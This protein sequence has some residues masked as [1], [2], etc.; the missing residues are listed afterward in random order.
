[1][2]AILEELE[3]HQMALQTL[4]SDSGIGSF[5]DDVFHWQKTLQTVEVI[6]HLWLEVQEKW[7]ELEEVRA[8]VTD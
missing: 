1:M 7:T 8:E 4:Q 6:L 5:M 2:E 3:S